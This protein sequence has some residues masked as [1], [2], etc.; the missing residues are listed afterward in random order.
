MKNQIHEIP[1]I[2]YHRI[3]NKKDVELG[4]CYSEINSALEISEFITQINFL[5]KKYSIISLSKLIAYLKG[6]ADVPSNSCVISFDDGYIDHYQNV[7]P[8]LK[9]LG[10]PA[11]FF[12]MGDCISGTKK[13][14]WLDK[15]YYIL[16]NTPYQ[17]NSDKFNEIVS[18]FYRTE[19]EK[20]NHYDDSKLKTFIRN[21]SEKD[22]IID[23]LSSTLNVK[24]D[25]DKINKKL[26]L[27]KENIAEMLNNG[28]EFGAHTMSHPDLSTI[29][30]EDSEKEIKDSGIIVRNLTNKEEIPF[31]YPFGSQ[32]TYNKNIVRIL[33]ENNFSCALTS[34]TGT[35]NTETSLFELKRIDSANLELNKY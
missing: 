27:S 32:K 16:D 18:D 24:L 34:I 11:V 5:N 35:N 12:I 31:A 6:E 8:I 13:V 26:Y 14:R 29:T 30:L 1:I 25:L 9:E 21:S 19:V 20:D 23:K 28:M 2:M 33:K 10:L 7:F 17:K 4:S 15:F 22:T 3:L